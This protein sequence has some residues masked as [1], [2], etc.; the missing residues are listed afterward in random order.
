MGVGEAAILN[1]VV[2][3]MSSILGNAQSHFYSGEDAERNFQLNESAAIRADQRARQMYKDFYSP[4]ALLQQY[5]EAGLSPSLM[6]GGGAGA[7]GT[8]V[9]GAQGEGASGTHTQTFG[10]SPIDIA[11]LELM[12]AQ[13]RKTNAEAASE[14]GESEMGK[15]RIALNLEQAGLAKA[16]QCYT[17]AQTTYQEL[18]N[19]IADNTKEFDIFKAKNLAYKE[20][21]NLHE[22]IFSALDKQQEYTINTET[23]KDRARIIAEEKAKIIAETAHLKSKRKLTDQE[24]EESQARI[25][26]MFDRT[27]IDWAE[28]ENG[29]INAD[30]YK[31]W[32]D[33]KVPYIEKELNLEAERLGIENKRIWLDFGGDVLKAGASLCILGNIGKGGLTQPTI[34]KP[35]TQSRMSHKE[36]GQ[37]VRNRKGRLYDYKD[38][39]AE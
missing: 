19:Y 31:K 33:N 22:A 37:T 13:T 3:G 39:Y 25:T 32:I 27:L 2:N 20:A 1:G 14:E 9:Q 23:F 18:Q 11:Q 16:S 10:L 36:F 15:S 12:K 7:G 26:R 6:F 35:T 28:A 38:I 8:T 34:P 29:K 17:E 4:A 30:S 21:A 5:K 24:I